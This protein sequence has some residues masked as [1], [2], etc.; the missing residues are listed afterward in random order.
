MLLKS[1]LILTTLLISGCF[2]S[3]PKPRPRP[4]CQLIRTDDPAN[5]F[6][7]CV[8]SDTKQEYS[9]KVNDLPVKAGD[10]QD[11]YICTTLKGYTEL[12]AYQTELV[13]WIKNTC[14]R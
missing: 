3:M 10:D 13:S 1:L 6:L 12:V 5:N 8:W 2:G 4:E 7:Y 14:R 11:I 9:V